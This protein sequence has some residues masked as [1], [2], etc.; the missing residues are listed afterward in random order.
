LAEN[1]VDTEEDM[2]S[3]M[4]NHDMQTCSPSGQQSAVLS[5]KAL[6]HIGQMSLQANLHL[7]TP[8]PSSSGNLQCNADHK[9][10]QIKLVRNCQGQCCEKFVERSCKV[11]Q[12]HASEFSQKWNFEAHPCKVLAVGPNSPIS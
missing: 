10:I 7:H 8:N 3:L 9:Q 5:S 1:Q 4:C 6:V 11:H 12:Q 2:L